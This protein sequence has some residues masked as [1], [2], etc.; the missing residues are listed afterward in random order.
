[1]RSCRGTLLAV[2]PPGQAGLEGISQN[3]HRNAERPSP[4]R[5][6][7]SVRGGL[8]ENPTR[9]ATCSAFAATST[10]ARTQPGHADGR[11]LRPRAVLDLGGQTVIREISCMQPSPLQLDP[12]GPPRPP[13]SG[14]ELDCGGLPLPAR[15]AVR[16]TNQTLPRGSPLSRDVPLTEGAHG[17]RKEHDAHTNHA[18]LPRDYPVVAQSDSH[19]TR[20]SGRCP[21]C[22]LTA[23]RG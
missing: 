20:R 8:A 1:M 22:C 17:A 9:E 5:R 14:T 15:R 12:E 23:R 21:S 7:T 6:W 13:G 18:D 16:A 3:E 10:V 4:R 2:D 11:A 19:S